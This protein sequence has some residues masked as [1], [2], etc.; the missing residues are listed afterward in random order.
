MASIKDMQADFLDTLYEKHLA[1][2]LDWEKREG[3]DSFEARLGEHYV[4]VDRKPV[5]TT[6]N[7]RIW[8][9]D[10]GGDPV[11]NFDTKNMT[12][13]R[14][15]NAELETFSK[16]AGTIYRGLRDSITATKIQSALDELKA[17]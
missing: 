6:P 1:G 12:D 9:F 14:P 13:I 3:E 15:K 11:F 8:L 4:H 10:R 2:K 16:L 17:K 5:G 7:Y